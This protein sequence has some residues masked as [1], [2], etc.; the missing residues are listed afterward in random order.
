MKNL[1]IFISLIPTT[2]YADPYAA[3]DSIIDGSAG[4]RAGT[5]VYNSVNP[6]APLPA[7]SSD[8]A[9]I[10][11]AL[12]NMGAGQDVKEAWRNAAETESGNASRSSGDGK[13]QQ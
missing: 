6:S 12:R 13:G 1:L 4:A 10:R 3:H 11:G 8:D 9:V 2:V 5:A 7:P